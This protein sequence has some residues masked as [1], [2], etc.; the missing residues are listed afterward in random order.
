M[1]SLKPHHP[2]RAFTLIEILVVIVVIAIL[3]A[4]VAPNV[5]QHVGEAKEVAARSQIEMIGG[6]LD[7]YRLHNGR[8]PN[9][10]EGLAALRER[11]AGDAAANW[12]GPYLRKAIPADPW[13]NAYLYSSPG[14]VNADSYDLLSLGADGQRGGEGE[15][16]DVTSW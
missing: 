16:K 4:L 11:P 14:E 7:A 6:A 8:Y 13:G 2:R 1:A 5:F 10:E 15:A 3:A 12:R 9:S